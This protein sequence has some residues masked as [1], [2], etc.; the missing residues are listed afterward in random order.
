[1][2][3]LFTVVSPPLF[4]LACAIAFLAGAVKGAVGFALPMIMIAGFGSVVAPDI[5][6]AALIV[7]T[8]VTNIFQALRDGFGQALASARRHWRFV[9]TVLAFIALSAQ[10]VTRLAPDAFV[11]ILGVPVTVFAALQLAG[12]R[13]RIAPRNRRRAE[14]GMG[15]AAGTIGGISGVWGPPT[16]MYLTALDTPKAEQMRV[17]GV[18]Y[19]AGSVALLLAHLRSGILG[20]GTLPL[21]AALTVPA[22]AGMVLGSWVQSRL[23]QERFRR[24]TLLVLVIAGLN[25]VRRGLTG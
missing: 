21:S 16:V 3:A 19:A 18:V 20:P 7:P 25:L 23:D 9:A 5:A 13:L 22:M 8:L 17:Q 10:L 15:A 24:A 12:W 4:V 2:D 11:L 6:L 1:M 14:L